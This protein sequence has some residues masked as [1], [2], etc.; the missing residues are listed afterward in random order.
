MH[1]I[2]E[3][4]VKLFFNLVWA[5]RENSFF[6]ATLNAQLGT[7]SI[8]TLSFD[9]GTHKQLNTSDIHPLELNIG[10]EC[11][12]SGKIGKVIDIS[13]GIFTIKLQD[14]PNIRT[15]LD[16]IYM[17]KETIQANTQ[18]KLCMLHPTS[19]RLLKGFTFFLSLS[20]HS[21]DGNGMYSLL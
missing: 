6:S 11:C 13:D 17:T 5:K 1:S 19:L 9:D 18:S 3:L 15:P 21:D 8:F 10:E 12:Y 2:V 7:S 14:Q 20:T 4:E 16:L